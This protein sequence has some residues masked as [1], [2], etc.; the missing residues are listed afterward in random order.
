MSE[1]RIPS[2]GSR[3][4]RGQALVLSTDVADEET[5]GPIDV[6]INNGMVTVLSPV[7]GMTAEEFQ[8]VTHVTNP[9]YVSETLSARR[10]MF[11]GIEACL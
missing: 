4:V 6:W 5:F 1:I 7:Q 2:L 10:P 9:G 8:R 11:L 3:K